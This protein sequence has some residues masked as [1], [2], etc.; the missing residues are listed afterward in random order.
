MSRG[1]LAIVFVLLASAL[2]AGAQQAR[3]VSRVGILDTE[4]PATSVR[5]EAFQRELRNLGWV[6]GQNFVTEARIG[7]HDRFPALAGQLARLGLD[8][9][10]APSTPAAQAAR[11]A[12]KSTPIVFALA[13]DP[14]G[15]GLVASLR[16]P[17][18][19]ITGTT[20]MGVDHL[21]AKQLEL[22]RTALPRLTRVAVLLNPQLPYSAGLVRGLEA[23]AQTLSVQLHL[24]KWDDPGGLVR[25]FETAATQRAEALLLLPNPLT[26]PYLTRIHDLAARHR[27]PT[28]GI[29]RDFA[30]SG[31]FMSYGADFVDQYRRAAVYVDRILRGAKAGDLPVEQPTRFELVI[32][33]KTA[34]A[35]GL[36]VPPSVLLRADR[37][38]D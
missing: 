16:R 19:N 34:K 14:V 18:G 32:N 6:E 10:F 38:I 11:S 12:T 15:S 2:T 33:L 27:L 13:P 20:S 9:I 29:T 31:G 25:A 7:P 24:A 26:I 4:G 8:V 22:L 5:V 28:I 21:G 1:V 37:V 23:A 35:L 3:K 36:T 17:G 30:E